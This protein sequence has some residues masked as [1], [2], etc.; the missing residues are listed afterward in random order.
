ML[1]P[2]AGQNASLLRSRASLDP[3]HITALIDE[4][5]EF[6]LERV[7]MANGLEISGFNSILNYASLETFPADVRVVIIPQ[8][9]AQMEYSGAAA[10]RIIDFVQ[11][12]GTLCVFSARNTPVVRQI[13]NKL[14]VRI[15]AAPNLARPLKLV[16]SLR[17]PETNPDFGS[18]AWRF[19]AP[20][21]QPILVDAKGQAAGVLCHIGSGT[22]ACMPDYGSDGLPLRGIGQIIRGILPPGTLISNER[23]GGWELQPELTVIEDGISYSYTEQLSF[24]AKARIPRFREIFNYMEWECPPLKGSCINKCRGKNALHTT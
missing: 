15:D 22:V 8:R 17:A 4:S 10:S 11:G 14:G 12:G 18:G 24:K 1:H 16:E 2:A 3:R 20:N 13:L 9:N 23:G 7:P 6:N 19:S 5:I 21:S